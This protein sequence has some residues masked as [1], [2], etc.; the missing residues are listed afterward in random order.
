MTS[1]PKFS[2]SFAAGVLMAAV[3]SAGWLPLD[4]RAEQAA[5]TNS[6]QPVDLFDAMDQGLVD[7]KFVARNAKQGRLVFT[8]QTKQPVSILVPE[9]F[10]GVPVAFKQGGF[11]GGG[12][13]RG[14]GGFGGGGGGGGGQQSV[15]GGGGRG[16]GGFGGGGRGGGGGGMFNVAPEKIGRLDVPLLCLNHG[17][18]D[19]SSSKPYE[20]RPIEDVVDSPALIEI[21][22]AYAD[23]E[24]P[25]AA[26]QAA[27]WHINSHVSWVDLASKLTGTVRSVVRGPYFSSQEIQAAMMLVHRAEAMTVGQEIKRR[28]WNPSKNQEASLSTDSVE[29]PYEAKETKAIDTK[30]ELE[31]DAEV[32]G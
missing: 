15:G 29:V 5:G 12:G 2:A 23:G 21:V 14:G 24:L 20:I 27:V 4:A 9:A 31:A 19:P 30:A 22:K 32:E 1:S 18:R 16:G 6:P 26:S 25:H 13:G 3:F 7:V 10:A 8:N 17:L 28:N 11:G